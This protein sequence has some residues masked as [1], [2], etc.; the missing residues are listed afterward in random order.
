MKQRPPQ[1]HGSD[2]QREDLS[3]IKHLK[4]AKPMANAQKCYLLFQKLHV[5]IQLFNTS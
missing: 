1:G 2:L 5:D 4:C 3:Y